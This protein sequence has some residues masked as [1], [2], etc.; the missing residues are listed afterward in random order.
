MANIVRLQS[1][2]MTPMSIPPE[3]MYNE[4]VLEKI[5]CMKEQELGRTRSFR[6]LS[7]VK[8][9]ANLL[10]GASSSQP[11][12]LMKPCHT[13]SVV[14]DTPL[15]PPPVPTKTKFDK[16]KAQ[17]DGTYT[18]KDPSFESA[19]EAPLNPLAL[20]ED[21]LV[22]YIVAL[23]SRSGNVVGRILRSRAAADELAVNELYNILLEEPNKFQAAAEVSVDVLFASFEKFLGRAW[24]EHMGP[25][26]PTYVVQ[27]MQSSF[28]SG[29]PVAF[30]Q[31]V[32]KSLD[33][34]SPQNRRA[35][36]SIMNLLLELLDA[37]G[38]D[39]DRGALT[40]SFAEALI[41]EGNP[42]DYI[43]LLDRLVDDYDELF[44]DTVTGPQDVD[45]FTG[46]LTRTRSFNTGSISS[47]ASSLRKKFGFGTLTRENS[48][49]ES[50][51]KVTSIWRTLSKN[52][53]SAGDSHSQPPS[54]SKSPGFSL[55]RSKST[56]N[57]V[58]M[59]PPLRPV[60]REKATTSDPIPREEARSRPGSSHLYEPSLSRIGENTPTKPTA[61][62]KKKRRS[63]LSDLR[64]LH[65]PDPASAWSPLQPRKLPN[66]QDENRRI[67]TPTRTPS[68]VKQSPTQQIKRPSPQTSGLPRRFGSPQRK[69]NS[70]M[71]EISPQKA[72]SPRA[73]GAQGAV[74]L[75]SDKVVITTYSP[76][77]RKTSHS[78]IPLPKDGLSERKWPPNGQIGLPQKTTPS[79]QKLRMQSPQKIRERLSQ[80]QKK[81]A[82]SDESFQAEMTKIG[83]EMATYKI[84]GTPVKPRPI[85]PSSRSAPPTSDLDSL[86]SQLKTLSTNLS[87]FTETQKASLTSIS[88]D[89]ESS[90]IVSE[91][92]ARK[93]DELYR[94]ANA[95]NEAL[96]ERFNDELGR[97]LGKVRG[98]QGL[99]E[100]RGELKEAQD[101]VVKLKRENGK[102]RRE[103]VGL[104][105]LLKG[106]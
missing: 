58:R 66:V 72:S 54:L 4:V 104:R 34:M 2:A 45:G 32:K 95:E 28:D 67:E 42:H 69:E 33:D 60:S 3:I 9:L 98:G 12:T 7:P 46:S 94:E 52:A 31:Q 77:N 87:R 48:K 105:S 24:K 47:N 17:K 41:Y 81:L 55:N 15:F 40:A 88:S 50:E 13:P 38:N 36:T 37:S 100:M 64:S 19:I 63:S 102:L 59:L 57:D 86:S 71:R 97:I 27:S 21:T 106:E 26:L 53:K 51:S 89:V 65:E 44:S 61:F 49:N 39:G 85:I 5:P 8:M 29:Q 22:A 1:Q 14:K 101:E 35:F 11:N 76:Q 10:G 96:Y 91:K 78:G 90:L 79:A 92:K 20:L 56:D 73:Q 103:A 25:L 74:N 30:K 6:P 83:E 16:P 80:E 93:L 68:P 62:L 75:K 43:L 84:Q 70:P 18:D 23:R 82:I 99:E